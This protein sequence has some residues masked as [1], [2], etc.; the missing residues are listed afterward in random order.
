MG[1]T[2]RD[3]L[4]VGL[5]VEAALGFQIGP[6]KLGGVEP[7]G[8]V[9]IGSQDGFSV[10]VSNRSGPGGNG[11]AGGERE[12]Q[13]RSNGIGKDAGGDVGICEGVSKA[14]GADIAGL[15]S[16]VGGAVHGGGA[17]IVA[18]ED[19]GIGDIIFDGDAT[20]EIGG[21]EQG[22]IHIERFDGAN[23]F[24][25]ADGGEY[26]FGDGD[27]VDGFLGDQ[28]GGERPLRD[29][30]VLQGIGGEPS[31]EIAVCFE[32]FDVAGELKADVVGDV[33]GEDLHGFGTGGL[34]LDESMGADVSQMEPSQ[35]TGY[36]DLV[37]QLGGRREDFRQTAVSGDG[38]DRD[39]VFGFEEETAFVGGVEKLDLGDV[40]LGVPAIFEI[41]DGAA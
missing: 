24:G 11:N 27:G 26:A 17:D 20:D 6:N 8:G 38:A 39:S 28:I 16:I 12:V 2:N 37:L 1:I 32:E 29:Q 13:G 34:N 15:E 23:G 33:G 35:M 10:D 21:A 3:L 14:D 40:G 41:D 18:G 5:D 36:V 22:V 30:D 25:T 9:R 7:E 4:Q 19:K 31:A